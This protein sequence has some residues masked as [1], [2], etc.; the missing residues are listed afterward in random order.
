M[1]NTLR[2][3]IRGESGEDLIEY[4]LLVAFVASVALAAILGDSGLRQG[5]IKA[6]EAAY[7]ALR[8]V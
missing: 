2:R 1:V 7:S 4:A 6:Y 8:A 5:V 3:F